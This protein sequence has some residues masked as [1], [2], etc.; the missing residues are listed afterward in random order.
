MQQEH[1]PIDPQDLSEWIEIGRL[2][3]TRGRIGELFAVFDASRPD[4]ADD[5]SRVL[6]RSGEQQRL[7]DVEN[8]WYHDGRPVM[9]FSGIDSISDAEPWSGAS[10][11]IPEAERVELEEGEYFHEDLVGCR[12]EISP[13]GEDNAAVDVGEVEAVEEHGGP[14]LLRVKLT[15]DYGGAKAG[16]HVLIPFRHEI[17]HD[18]DIAGKR[19]RADVPEGLLDL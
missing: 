16:K 5:L 15:R 11:W 14:A 19:I 8:V 4:R 7:V 18:I 17:C 2:L 3:R 12:F 9:K 13:P 10:I 1:A 6:L